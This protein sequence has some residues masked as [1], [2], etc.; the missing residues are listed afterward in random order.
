VNDM[1][2][3]LYDEL[4]GLRGELIHERNERI[5]NSARLTVLETEAGYVRKAVIGIV[6]LVAV[7]LGLAVNGFV[8]WC[9]M[10]RV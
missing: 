4:K 1:D 3:V 6:A 7:P 8:A 10:P 5:S 2:R 9:A